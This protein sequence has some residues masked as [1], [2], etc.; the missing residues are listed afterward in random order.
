MKESSQIAD[1]L[2]A[3]FERLLSRIFPRVEDRLKRLSMGLL[4]VAGLMWTMIIISVH[5]AFVRPDADAVGTCV[6]QCSAK[7]DAAV[8]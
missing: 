4:L 1:E 7:G 2:I 6:L 5:L 8:R 3:G